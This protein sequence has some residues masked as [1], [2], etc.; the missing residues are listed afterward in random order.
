MHTDAHGPPHHTRSTH[1]PAH[2]VP[3]SHAAQPW[4]VACFLPDLS[5]HPAPDHRTLCC[6]FQRE[7]Q[8]CDTDDD[9]AMCFIKNQAAFEKYLEFLVGRVQAESAVVGTAVQEF[10]KVPPSPG[11]TDY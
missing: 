5:V 8:S 6:S 4:V 7:L 10:Y 11:P 3:S 2:S 1:N 9:V